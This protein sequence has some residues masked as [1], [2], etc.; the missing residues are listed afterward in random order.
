MKWYLCRECGRAFDKKKI[1]P[2]CGKPLEEANISRGF[3]GSIP[4]ILAGVALCLL[5]V[6]F[7]TDY[8]L[9]IWLT[10]PII[11]AGLIYDHLY[12][13]HVEKVLKDMIK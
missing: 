3:E 2:S 6:S 5:I 12:Q 13:K 8:F 10:F 1:C 4:F 11:A 9:L 7:L